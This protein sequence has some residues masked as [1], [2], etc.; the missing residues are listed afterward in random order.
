M[1]EKQKNLILYLERQCQ[2]KNIKYEPLIDKDW[3]DY[4]KN[5][6]PDFA[7]VVINALKSILGLPIETPKKRRRKWN[8]TSMT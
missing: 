8:I 4:Y 7:S 5:Y 1:T 6:S 3:V 2:I